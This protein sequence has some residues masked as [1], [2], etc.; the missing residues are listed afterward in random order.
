MVDCPG[1]TKPSDDVLVS[2]VALN[3]KGIAWPFT[4][5]ER[6]RARRLTAGSNA[7]VQIFCRAGVFDFQLDRVRRFCVAEIDDRSADVDVVNG[8]AGPIRGDV[9]RERKRGSFA[10]RLRTP[11]IPFNT[12][13]TTM[14]ADQI[15]CGELVERP[16]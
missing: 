8:E 2:A 1:P 14:A 3:V 13:A 4:S 7:S 5:A 10:R 16:W 9:R 6:T 12:G 11:N 15:W